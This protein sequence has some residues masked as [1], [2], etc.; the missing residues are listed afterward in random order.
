MSYRANEPDAQMP[1]RVFL[2]RIKRL[3]D[4][5][6]D[7]TAPI[8]PVS[9]A[10]GRGKS[11]EYTQFSV[12]LMVL[13]LYF[14]DSGLTQGDA[15]YILHN[16]EATLREHYEKALEKSVL[17]EDGNDD[18]PVFFLLRKAELRE[19]WSDLE[20]GPLFLNPRFCYGLNELDDAMR[21]LGRNDP[22]RLVIQISD[23]AVMV[24]RYLSRNKIVDMVKQASE[25][26]LKKKGNAAKPEG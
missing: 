22:T 4:L 10:V 6:D 1:P 19:C 16:L 5:D 3:L 11:A 12:F 2:N 25:R 14:I 7:V 17:A 9:A 26:E 24:R 21:E 23:L 20:D 15:I 8:F 18:T 13:G